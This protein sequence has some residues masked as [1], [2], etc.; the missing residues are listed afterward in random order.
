MAL[1]NYYDLDTFRSEHPE[2]SAGL[3]KALQEYG[4]N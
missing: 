3:D 4:N 1:N 2:L